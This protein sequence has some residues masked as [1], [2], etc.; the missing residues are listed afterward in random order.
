MKK[1]ISLVLISVF[2]ISISIA[3]E[4]MWL[5]ML[6]KSLNESDM[7]SMGLKLSAED[8]YSVNQSS[9]KDAIVSFGGFCTGE[10]ISDQGLILTNHHCGY[11]QIQSHS[12][13]ENDYLT[14]GYWAMTNKEELQNPGLT[15]TFIVRMEDVTDVVLEGIEPTMTDADQQKMISEKIKILTK[16]A[17]EGT[18]YEAY[19]KPFFYGNEY[20][21]FITETFK[22]IRLVGAPPSSIGKF[23]GDTDNWM[24]PRHTGDF[25]M[26]RIYANKDNKPAEYSEDNVPFKPRNFLPISMNGIRKGDFT[27]VFGFPGRTQEYLTSYAISQIKNEINPKQIEIRR[28]ALDIMDKHMKADAKVRIQYASKYASIANYWKKWIGENNGLEKAG[29]IDKKREQEKAFMEATAGNT[30]FED[31]M[32][33]FRHRYKT[34]EPYAIARSYFIEIPYRKIELFSIAAAFRGVLEAE[35]VSQEKI[36]ALKK[37]V[38]KHFKDYDSDTDLELA[39]ALLAKYKADLDSKFVPNFYSK[40]GSNDAAFYQKIY[41]K[42]LFNS[43]EKLLAMLNNFSSS[44]AKKLKKDMAYQMMTQFFQIYNDAIR[45][46]YSRLNNEIDSLSK[47]YVKGLRDFV[48]GKYYPDANSTLRLAYGQVDN[49]KPRDAVKYDYFTDTEGIL[50]KYNPE[51]VDFDLPEKLVDLIEKKDY[52][53]YADDDGYMHVCFTASNHTT[54][55]NSGSPVINGK[56]ELIGLNFDRNWEGTMSDINYDV[57]QCRNIAVDIRYVLF[58]VD[59]FAGAGHLVKEMKLVKD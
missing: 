48:P 14:N 16:E 53:Q 47:I 58:I 21:M 31:L 54:G 59:K 23:G 49:Y 20:Y 42:S 43:K 9:L 56:G 22:D 45:P 5:P 44:S 4:G 13:V 29:A 46:E 27:M 24:W 1:I 34:I 8:I 2:S 26:F 30:S 50:E 18:H 19:V 11:G 12:S 51:H 17:T 15:A 41:Q 7:Q 52:G 6:L 35:D 55:G 33:Q 3:K 38:E 57:E 40:I 28:I 37:S 32:N 25:S 10:V 36:D 39:I